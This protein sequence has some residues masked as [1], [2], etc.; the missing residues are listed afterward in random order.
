MA[1][2][3]F[4]WGCGCIDAGRPGEAENLLKQALNKI[5]RYGG[6]DY[7]ATATVAYFIGYLYLSQDRPDESEGMLMRALSGAER[8]GD[9]LLNWAVI[10]ALMDL[11]EV[12]IRED[13]LV[14][15]EAILSRFLTS[16][17]R[18]HL[19]SE[20]RDIVAEASELWTEFHDNM[21]ERG[22]LFADGN[23]KPFSP[24]EI[25]AQV[26]EL[27]EPMNLLKLAQASASEGRFEDAESSLHLVLDMLTASP[28]RNENQLVTISTELAIIKAGLGKH[29]ESKRLFNKIILL[30]TIPDRLNLETQ[31]QI[32]VKCADYQAHA[33]ELEQAQKTLS[34]V[35]NIRQ[36]MA[37]LKKE[38]WVHKMKH[39]GPHS[40][41]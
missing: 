15:A 40:P 34:I 11:A 22:D 38:A 21:R 20:F 29:D 37:K 28:A 35:R 10:N 23:E 17:A 6:A 5:E 25:S 12:F 4:D 27:T 3:L 30:S 41:R 39:P 18:H 16:A 31:A 7:P 26:L 2:Q 32:F 8:I 9:E 33:G 24:E 19:D 14:E 36:R 1:G 13:A